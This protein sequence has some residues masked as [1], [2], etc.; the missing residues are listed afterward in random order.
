M[1]VQRTNIIFKISTI[2]LTA[3]ELKKRHLS[4]KITALDRAKEFGNDFYE[5][6]GIMFCKSC[7]H[8]VDS[9]RRQ[10]ALE[11]L[12][13]ARHKNRKQSSLGKFNVK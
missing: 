1:R 13:S 4:A 12:K 7:Q 6:G 11:H 5:D 10:T 9:P 3:E 2:K 8:S